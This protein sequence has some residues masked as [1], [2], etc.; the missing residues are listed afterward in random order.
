MRKVLA[1]D[2]ATSKEWTSLGGRAFIWF[3]EHTGGTWIFEAQNPEDPTDW[4]DISPEPNPFESKGWWWT[5][6]AAPVRY[7]LR[8]GNQGAIAWVSNAVGDVPEIF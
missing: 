5:D 8:G 4:I 2:V 3:T 7:R 1:A 6:M